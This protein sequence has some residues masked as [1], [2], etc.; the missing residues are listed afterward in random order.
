[1]DLFSVSAWDELLSGV[2]PAML[3]K[4]VLNPL[5]YLPYCRTFLC[6][7]SVLKVS[8]RYFRELAYRRFEPMY[9]VSALRLYLFLLPSRFHKE[10]REGFVHMLHLVEQI[11]RTI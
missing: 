3:I 11:Y 4:L 5:I 1:M 9:K 2:F 7:F 6:L 8:G 10:W